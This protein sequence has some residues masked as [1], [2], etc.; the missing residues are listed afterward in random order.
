MGAFSLFKH[1]KSRN[2]STV[3]FTKT[4]WIPKGSRIKCVFF[5]RL[6]VINSRPFFLWI[7]RLRKKTVLH[8]FLVYSNSNHSLNQY[9]S[10]LSHQ[11]VIPLWLY[12]CIIN[13]C[14]L[15]YS[16]HTMRISS[17]RC[18]IVQCTLLGWYRLLNRQFLRREWHWCIAFQ[19]IVLIL[20]PIHFCRRIIAMEYVDF[21]QLQL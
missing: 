12:Y 14:D 17:R 8:H 4:N 18:H 3:L 21:Y 13:T 16:V 6:L 1:T 7:E 2:C 19:V 5:V 15:V 20:T 9:D 11:P 10:Y